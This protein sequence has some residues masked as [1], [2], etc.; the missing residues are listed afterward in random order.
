[1]KVTNDLLWLLTVDSSLRLSFDL[2]T[3]FNTA[4]HN[5]LLQIEHFALRWLAYFVVPGIFKSSMA[6]DPSASG[7]SFGEPGPS[8][9]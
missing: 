2:S 1:M 5:M 7:P 6:A 8:L 4:D 3:A 9:D